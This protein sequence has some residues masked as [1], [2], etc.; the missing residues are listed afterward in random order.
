MKK[1]VLIAAI[2]AAASL[3]ACSQHAKNETVE[4]ANAVATD[5]NATVAAGVNSVDA[6]TDSA[7]NNISNA[8]DAATNK[9]ES[10]AEKM[11]HAT[12]NAMSDAGNSLKH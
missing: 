9:V 4:A 5:V 8:A 7:M 2:A 1:I 11:K 12:G 3:A 10:A 6:A